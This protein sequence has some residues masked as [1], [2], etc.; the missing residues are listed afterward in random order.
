MGP[1]LHTAV[2]GPLVFRLGDVLELKKTHPCGSKTWEIVR[3]GAD[4]GLV[5]QG[6]G[7]R[8]LMDRVRV[9]KALKR[10]VNREIE[11]L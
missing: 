6:C 4:I 9:E 5:C 1:A 10:G 11:R 8:V 7:H 2:K 3:L